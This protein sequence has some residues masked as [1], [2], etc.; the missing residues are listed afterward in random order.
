MRSSIRTVGD[1]LGAPHSW[2]DFHNGEWRKCLELNG[3]VIAEVVT[4]DK[5]IA[6]AT[7]GAKCGD[8]YSAFVIED[9]ALRTRVVQALRIGIAVHDALE[10][11]IG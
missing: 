11:E 5:G 1:V 10:I 2:P 8:T 6:I 7:Q 3:A 4:S 9:D